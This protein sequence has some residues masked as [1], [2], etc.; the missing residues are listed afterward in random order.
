LVERREEEAVVEFEEE[1]EEREVF[2]RAIQNTWRRSHHTTI[3][4]TRYAQHRRSVVILVCACVCV[5][6]SRWSCPGEPV[7]AEAEERPKGR[8]LAHTSLRPRG[9]ARLRLE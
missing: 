3:D 9:K 4:G 6:V 8:A 7:R 1:E 5:T 2:V